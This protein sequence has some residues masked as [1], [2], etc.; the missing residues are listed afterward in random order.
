MHRV[1]P[2]RR[3]NASSASSDS[4]EHI[5]TTNPDSLLGVKGQEQATC[6]FGRFKRVNPEL[7]GDDREEARRE[8][9]RS[10]TREEQEEPTEEENPEDLHADFEVREAPCASPGHA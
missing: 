3:E 1:A 10:V 5:A 4:E 6:G 2:S 8:E 9:Q 7:D